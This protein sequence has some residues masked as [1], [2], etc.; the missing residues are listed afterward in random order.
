[1]DLE[2]PRQLTTQRG[3]VM[4]VG[5]SPWRITPQKL[6]TE[7]RAVNSTVQANREISAN[8]IIKSIIQRDGATRIQ[9]STDWQSNQGRQLLI[10]AV[11]GKV[12]TNTQV[13]GNPTYRDL[14]IRE[15]AYSAVQRL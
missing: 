7:T 10:N 11:I 1:M 2:Q 6:I 12:G 13:A 14:K 9:V 4:G 15:L 3:G 5:V 8:A